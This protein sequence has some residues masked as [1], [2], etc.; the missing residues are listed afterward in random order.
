M[1]VLKRDD[2]QRSGD[3][4]VH[5]VHTILGPESTFEGK[6]LFDGT[7]R[8]DGVF[9]GEVRTEN[10]LVVGQSARIEAQLH[11]GHI[12]INGEII[13]DIVATRSV[14][15]HA[16]GKVRGNIRTPQLVIDRGVIFEGQSHMEEALHVQHSPSPAAAGGAPVALVSPLNDS[17]R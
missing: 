15:I 12:V 13:G 4:G 9:K 11:V 17:L 5:D 14:E 1:A 8:I 6:L 3:L 7:V 16:P 2:S 10:T